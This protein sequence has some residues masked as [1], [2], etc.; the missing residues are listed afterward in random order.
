MRN[1]VDTCRASESG[2]WWWCLTVNNV[3]AAIACKGHVNSGS[4]AHA[5]A[6]ALLTFQ[7]DQTF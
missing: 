7:F 4:F 3:C 2:M 6:D 5:H 1:H